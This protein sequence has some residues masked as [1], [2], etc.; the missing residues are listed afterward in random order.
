MY[1]LCVS[2][3]VNTQGFV[4]KFFMRYIYIFIHSFI[5]LIEIGHGGS[6][7]LPFLHIATSFSILWPVVTQLSK[8]DPQSTG[9]AQS[10]FRF[11][12]PTWP[13]SWTVLR[14]VRKQRKSI[15]LIVTWY[16]HEGTNKLNDLNGLQ[17][18]A[19]QCKRYT[20]TDGCFLCDMHTCC[21]CTPRCCMTVTTPISGK[22]PDK[23][24][25][26]V[27]DILA[28]TTDCHN[29]LRHRSRKTVS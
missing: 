27:Y 12:H 25:T 1:A 6:I 20:P 26:L 18:S 22:F 3:A 10:H 17:H 9:C 4:W 19:S 11:C 5:H 24:Q 29:W 21:T 15:N 14:L 16:N 28:P 2:G 7:R 13:A 23:F 8:T